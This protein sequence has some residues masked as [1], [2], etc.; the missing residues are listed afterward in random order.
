[1]AKKKQVKRKTPPSFPLLFSLKLS[2][3]LAVIL[4][5]ILGF[6]ILFTPFLGSPLFSGQFLPAL[7]VQSSRVM[8]AS[9]LLIDMRPG[10]Q[11]KLL[12]Y[13]HKTVFPFDYIDPNTNMTSLIRIIQEDT[14]GRSFAEILG[15]DR[16]QTFQAYNLARSTG[17]DPNAPGNPF[18]VIT[19]LYEFGYTLGTDRT[20]FYRPLDDP[21]HLLVESP[22]I[23]GVRIED[24]RRETYPYPDVRLSP[25]N[26]RKIADFILDQALVNPDLP[27]AR[28]NAR[29]QAR[30]FFSSLLRAT[31][32]TNPRIEFSH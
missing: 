31:G 25:D 11:L 7:L 30:Q 29:N 32:S 12:E 10:D 17:F 14:T 18:L 15:P 13:V 9:G 6:L 1:M 8:D 24:P 27:L 19:L 28:E 22:Q 2:F 20:P 21:D 4:A 16:Y 3:F 26:W 23:L 5:L